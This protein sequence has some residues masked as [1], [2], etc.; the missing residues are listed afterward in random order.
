MRLT[1]KYAN[2]CYCSKNFDERPP[3]PLHPITPRELDEEW[4][5]ERNK[6]GQLEDVEEELGIDLLIWAKAILKGI[7]VKG[8]EPE[9]GGVGTI[10]DIEHYLVE[11]FR[12][13]YLIVR[14][15][16]NHDTHTIEN[17]MELYGKTW[18]LTKD[19]LE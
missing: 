11:D 17:P 19:E 1:K 5:L 12:E 15:A 10:K 18:A 3:D 9:W 16:R 8:K 14:F 6:L 7:Y 2:G 4:E 13:Y